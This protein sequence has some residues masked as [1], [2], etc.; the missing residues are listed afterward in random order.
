[1]TS[2]RR[3]RVGARLAAGALVVLAASSMRDTPARAAATTTPIKHIVI[4]YQEN[5]SFDEVLGDFCITTFRCDGSIATVRL[6]DGTAVTPKVSPDQVPAVIHDVA[7]QQ[8]ALSNNW[9]LIGGCSAPTYPCITYFTPKQ[10]PAIA[11]L[12]GR[13]AVADRTFQS[14]DAPSWGAR[15]E[16]TAGTL[17]GFTGD[18]PTEGTGY[19]WGCDTK[20]TAPYGSDAQWVPACVPDPKL[21]LPNGGAFEPTPASYVPTI[22][23]RLGDAGLPWRIYAPTKATLLGG[24]FWNICPIFSECLNSAQSQHVALTSELLQDAMAGKLPAWS[25]VI[26]TP[27]VSQHNGH[28]MA[29]GDNW[30]SQAVSAIEHGPNWSTTAVFITWDDCGCFYDHVD[31]PSNDGVRAPMIIVSP[32]ARAG[33]TDSTSTTV[34]GGLLAY[35]EHTFGLPPLTSLDSLSYDFSNSFDYAQKAGPAPPLPALQP[36]TS[37]DS[38]LADPNDPT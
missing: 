23:D 38:P 37:S 31:P 22:M 26:P 1:M 5:H 8:L 15:V 13:F 35:V 30:I 25:I 29:R 6:A 21:G 17:D 28:S 10:I 32:Y 20:K 34:A 14:T 4:L 2:Q 12:A 36:V 33:Y 9:D 7:S 18:N 19:G 16:F 3:A 27:D 11:A 24:Y